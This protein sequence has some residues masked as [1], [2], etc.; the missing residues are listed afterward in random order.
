LCDI[1]ESKPH[2]C[3]QLPEDEAWL[4]L[5]EKICKIIKVLSAPSLP[6]YHFASG[7]D[8]G[9]NKLFLLYV[10]LFGHRLVR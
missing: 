2:G 3:A 6:Q 4:L 7:E 9:G 5:K 8:R 1:S 10:Y